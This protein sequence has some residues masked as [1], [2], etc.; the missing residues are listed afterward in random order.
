MKRGFIRNSAIV[1]LL[2]MLTACAG[3]E[4][5]PPSRE[6]K[7]TFPAADAQ[8]GTNSGSVTISRPDVGTENEKIAMSE[9]TKNSNDREISADKEYGVFIG[10]EYDGLPSDISYD[11]LVIDAQ[12]Y[13]SEELYQLH[14]TNKEIYSYLNVGSLEDFRPYYDQFKDIT[15]SPYENWDGEYWIDV[16]KEEWQEYIAQQIAPTL[17]RGGVDGFFIDNADIYYMYPTD[18][19]YDGLTTILTTIK[20]LNR[21]IIINGGNDYVTRYLEENGTLTP[22]LDGVNQESVFTSINWD[23]GTFTESAPDD[24]EYFLDYLSQVAA[25]GK[26]VYVLEY[27]KDEALAEMAKSKCHELGYKVYVSKNLELTGD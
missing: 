13:T 18:E 17:A 3:P 15:L 16:S 22:V 11:V 6:T 26:A 9:D 19:I 14:K 12:Y 10:V 25:D 4:S 2:V 27:T 24:R 21:K 5:T 7:T 8:T 23:E 1:L 20:K